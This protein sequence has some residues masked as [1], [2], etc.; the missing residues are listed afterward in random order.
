MASSP[1]LE[2]VTL[3]HHFQLSRLAA[4]YFMLASFVFMIYDHMITFA[5]EV[6]R[7]WQ[8]E[9]TGA[10]WLFFLNR[11]LT[12]LQFI[13]NL[14]S[15]H[16]PYWTGKVGDPVDPNYIAICEDFIPFPGASTLIS[17]AIAEKP[18]VHPLTQL[19][20]A[21][22][23]EATALYQ[24]NPWILVLLGV[25]WVGQ[26]IVM[27][28]VMRHPTRLRL[29]EGFVG[30]IQGGEGSY[31]GAFWLAPLATDSLV[32]LLTVFKSLGYI[33]K[34]KCRVPLIHVVLRDGI[35][36]FAIILFANLLNCFLYYLAP[37][38]IKVIGASCNDLALATELAI[39]IVCFTPRMP[40]SQ[41]PPLSS[42]PIREKEKQVSG[43]VSTLS[44]YFGATVED[45]GKDWHVSR[46]AGRWNGDDE[47]HRGTEMFMR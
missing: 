20:P 9:W 47:N 41:L 32:F 43:T 45:L 17:I 29:P 37:P 23:D 8:R 16:D 12:E 44:Y 7:V 25:F 24:R 38:S 6:D 40:T 35:L 31:V 10:T 11:Y 27:G 4:K 2:Y 26:V 30:C 28:T 5:E 46:R 22:T 42:P 21:Q 3:A 18:T 39:R 19:F 33:Y 14:V 13:V 36:Y 34:T 15:F 1:G